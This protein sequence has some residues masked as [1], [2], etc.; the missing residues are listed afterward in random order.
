MNDPFG[1]FLR[2]LGQAT[3]AE[4]R[5]AWLGRGDLR[6]QGDCLQPG[7]SVLCH[8]R[9]PGQFRLDLPR[10]RAEFRRHGFTWSDAAAEELG[11]ARFSGLPQSAA[12]SSPVFTAIQ[13]RVSEA[14]M[15]KEISDLDLNLRGT[16]G[17]RFPWSEGEGWWDGL[18]I[19][20]PK[21]SRVEMA[22]DLS[23][24]F[25]RQW[26]TD[27]RDPGLVAWP[28]SFQDGFLKHTRV[29]VYRLGSSRG[30][31]VHVLVAFV[32]PLVL[33]FAPESELEATG[34]G[35]RVEWR[36]W[37][38][39]IVRAIHSVYRS[40]K[41]DQE[42]DSDS[43]T[44]YSMGLDVRHRQIPELL[45][46]AADTQQWEC[47]WAGDGGDRLISRTPPK[48]SLKR[49]RRDFTDQLLPETAE[50][51][52]GRVRS[53]IDRH[54]KELFRGSI[55]IALL[56]EATGYR[57]SLL[58]DLILEL[59]R[60]DGTGEEGYAVRLPQG[61]SRHDL[62]Q[63]EVVCPSSKEGRAVRAQWYQPRW[64]I[65]WVWLGVPTAVGTLLAHCVGVLTD[66]KSVPLWEAVLLSMATGSALWLVNQYAGK[67]ARDS[68][69]A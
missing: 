51:R 16:L 67:R 56:R 33:T 18:V 64:W 31:V 13:L 29:L 66:G 49:Y 27:Q 15:R 59:E 25:A 45:V 40:W 48:A 11:A 58:R 26:E 60:L 19:P 7:A 50:E 39:T 32:S 21:V 63:L 46:P 6:A 36:P 9:F 42:R 17:A 47:L 1:P 68:A 57:R 12:E 54:R 28:K 37:D 3:R 35:L 69:D 30:R 8:P 65:R 44:Y 20:F 23:E 24:A 34:D 53:I 5:V 22:A 43:F 14:A 52:L 4:E 41:V 10:H 55:N 38:V 62:D 2:Q 61:K